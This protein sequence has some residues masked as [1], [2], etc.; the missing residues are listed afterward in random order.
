MST[1]M[2]APPST[3]F[4]IV[5]VP[6]NLS[7]VIDGRGVKGS[8]IG[9]TEEES[10]WVPFGENA[11]I[12]HLA[13]DEARNARRFARHALAVGDFRRVVDMERSRHGRRR[14]LAR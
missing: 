8:F 7:H 9:P 4:K 6:E 11:A 5:D 2:K 1:V 13:F 14:R 10:P 3:A 12:R